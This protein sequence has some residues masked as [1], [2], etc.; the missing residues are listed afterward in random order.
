[1]GTAAAPVFSAM[2][3]R[4]AFVGRKFRLGFGEGRKARNFLVQRI[5]TLFEASK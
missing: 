1:M 4:P 2:M 3:D 5:S